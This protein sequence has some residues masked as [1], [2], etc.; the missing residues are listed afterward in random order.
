M[1]DVHGH[2]LTAAAW[3][4]VSA[5]CW[6]CP[7]P[8]LWRPHLQPNLQVSHHHVGGKGDVGKRAGSKALQRV[9]Q[10]SQ[11]LLRTKQSQFTQLVPFTGVLGTAARLW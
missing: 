6:L 11:A 3:A 7:A 5:G 1:Q 10:P 9:E 2:A 8:G 4:A